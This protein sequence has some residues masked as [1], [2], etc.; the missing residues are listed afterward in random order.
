MKL[1]RRTVL[2]GLGGAAIALPLCEAM[3]AGKVGAAPSPK[4]LVV[5]VNQNGASM[6]RWRPSSGALDLS[7]SD[8]LSPL[9]GY[10][11]D[12]VLVDGVDCKAAQQQN[13]GVSGVAMLSGTRSGIPGAVEINGISI[14]QRVAQVIGTTTKKAS[15]QLGLLCG[16]SYFASGPGQRLP[17]ANDPFVAFTDLFRD[18]QTDSVELTR[19]RRRRESVLDGVALDLERLKPRLGAADRARVDAHLTSIREVEK[20]LIAGLSCEPPAAIGDT[21]EVWENENY[22]AVTDVHCDL[23]T[24][25]LGCDATRVACLQWDDPGG[26]WDHFGS[27]WPEVVALGSEYA[28]MWVHDIGHENGE[29]HATIGRWYAARL[30]TLIDRLKS[31]IEPDGSTLFDNTVILWANEM[32]ESGNHD[33]GNCPFVLAGGAN[34]GLATGQWVS[35]PHPGYWGGS[36]SARSNNDLLLSVLRLFDIDDATFGDADFCSGPVT[37]ILA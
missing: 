36:A 33:P 4:R 11:A 24:L 3:L 21:V 17:V 8:Y 12:V 1:S 5:L 19:L 10:E 14:D 32:G 28:N 13:H 9:A 22:A 20:R 37:Q 23:M 15:L 2:R 35:L 25:A 31:R 6:D 27:S 30:A 16:E 26:T 7:T 34:S 18:F 29:A